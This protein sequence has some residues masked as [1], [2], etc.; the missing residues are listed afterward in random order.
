[1]VLASDPVLSLNIGSQASNFPALIAFVSGNPQPTTEQITWT[2]NGAPHS[3][4]GK[5]LPLSNVIQTSHAGEYAVTVST[6]A[7]TATAGFTVLVN[8]ECVCVGGGG[9]GAG[10]QWSIKQFTP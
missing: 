4:T 5:S 2:Q 1:M 8:G 9:H 3:T 10:Q 7:G 6:S